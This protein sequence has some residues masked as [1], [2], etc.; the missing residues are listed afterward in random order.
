VTVSR[1]NS[2]LVIVDG[3][4]VDPG[5]VPGDLGGSCMLSGLARNLRVGGSGGLEC[6]MD[7]DLNTF[8][9]VGDRGYVGETSSDEISGPD[10]FTGGTLRSGCIGGGAISMCR[11]GDAEFCRGSSVRVTPNTRPRSGD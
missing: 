4:G 8:G 7:L 9:E 1:G 3:A 6:P 10:V 11:V 5:V 2:P